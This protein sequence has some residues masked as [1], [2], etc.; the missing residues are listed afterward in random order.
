[1]KQKNI[2]FLGGII[3][4][5]TGRKEKEYIDSLSQEKLERNIQAA[6]ARLEEGNL[7]VCQKQEYEKTL[8]HLE[9][10]QK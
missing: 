7:S 9:K 6:K 4:R 10:Y 1:M 8:R 3:S 2:N 5:L